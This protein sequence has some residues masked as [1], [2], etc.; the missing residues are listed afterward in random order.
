MYEPILR[1]VGAPDSLIEYN[2]HVYLADQIIDMDSFNTQYASISGGT[3]VNQLPTL[4][5]NNTF[6][7]QGQLFTA[8]TSTSTYE[9]VTVFRG[10]YPV[11]NGGY[12]K[13]PDNTETFFFQL[14]AGWYEVTPD[15][16]SPDDVVITGDVFTGQN[17]DIQ[18]Q[19]IPFTYGQQYL[20][21]YRQ[22]PYMTLGFA[23]DK[24]VDNN[25]SWLSNDNKI[26]T[27]IDAN[28]NAYYFV[29]DEKL[30]LNVKNVDIMLNPGQGLSYDVWYMSNQYNFPI[31]EQGL[32]QL[33]GNHRGDLYVE[34]G[35]T[36]PQNLTS[37]QL[38]TVRSLIHQ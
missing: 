6:S 36:I 18:T 37:E 8:F 27:S 17:F 13:S 34:L 5:P 11:D 28:Y 3:Y 16:R 25:K 9:S 32:F 23:L 15:H 20:D 29:G 7:F 2:E 10:E 19:L 21:R 22:F 38:E 33:N 1:L 4:S 30:V 31:P 24:V 12:P 14:G 35:I 26:R